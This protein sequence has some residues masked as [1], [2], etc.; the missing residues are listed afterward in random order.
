ML[1]DSELDEVLRVLS[2]TDE[3]LKLRD[4]A[5]KALKL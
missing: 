4:L 5:K 2:D 1:D 3:N